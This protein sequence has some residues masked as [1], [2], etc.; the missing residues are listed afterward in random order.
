MVSLDGRIFDGRATSQFSS[1]NILGL[2]LIQIICWIA[3]LG[4]K[5]N[6]HQNLPL[7]DIAVKIFSKVLNGIRP[8]KFD[9]STHAAVASGYVFSL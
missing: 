4:A 7:D 1:S 6:I 2:N 3:V 9:F 5:D 8:S